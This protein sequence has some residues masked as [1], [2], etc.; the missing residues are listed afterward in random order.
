MTRISPLTT[1]GVRS[2]QGF[3]AG[4]NP[5][6]SNKTPRTSAPDRTAAQRDTHSSPER[7]AARSGPQATRTSPTKMRMRV[8]ASEAAKPS[9]FSTPSRQPTSASA[10]TT[11]TA[12]PAPNAPYPGGNALRQ[13]FPRMTERTTTNAQAIA[14]T[15]E[16][17]LKMLNQS[18]A[19]DSPW[20]TSRTT[21]MNTPISP[22]ARSRVSQANRAPARLP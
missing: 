21:K 7:S 13:G 18:A 11:R 19:D 22:A 1:V 20:T 8:G 15:S 6:G 9:G 5:A 12:E 17:T 14:T 3:A 16:P 2:S 4:W 10:A